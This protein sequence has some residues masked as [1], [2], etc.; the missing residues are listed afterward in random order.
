MSWFLPIGSCFSFFIITNYIDLGIFGEDKKQIYLQKHLFNNIGNQLSIVVD[1]KPLS[2][3]ID[4][5]SKLIEVGIEDNWQE[6]D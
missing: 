2:V 1:E 3:A 4:P 5:Y 6:K